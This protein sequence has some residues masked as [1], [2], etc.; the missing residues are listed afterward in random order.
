MKYPSTEMTREALEG[1]KVA[2]S[3]HTTNQWLG[4]RW[5]ESPVEVVVARAHSATYGELVRLYCNEAQ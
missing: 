2:N 4:E 1:G 5:L 3:S